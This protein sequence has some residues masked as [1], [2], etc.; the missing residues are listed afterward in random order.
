MGLKAE[1]WGHASGLPHGLTRMQSLARLTLGFCFSP[2]IISAVVNN[3]FGVVGLAPNAK[4]MCLK[5]MDEQGS[6]FTSAA[7]LAMAYAIQMNATVQNHSWGSP[8]SSLALQRIARLSGRLGQILAAAAGN[9]G[10]D[11]DVIGNMTYPAALSSPELFPE[12]SDYIISVGASD[13]N[14]RRASFSNY[15]VTTVDIS[16]PGTDILS[17]DNIASRFVRKQGTSM[18]TPLVAATAAIVSTI[19][20]LQID[21]IGIANVAT[22]ADKAAYTKHI[23]MATIDKIETLQVPS[24]IAFLLRL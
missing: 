17:L 20:C 22:A 12:T 8:G 23:I 1:P 7:V 21:A 14:D 6:G 18:A 24:L 4:I 5:F 10:I 11:T 19:L 13:E 15:G 16:A 9:D 2:G 3:T